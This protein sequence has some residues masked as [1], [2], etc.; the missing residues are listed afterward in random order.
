MTETVTNAGPAPSDGGTQPSVQPDR[1]NVDGQI[2]PAD[3]S[4][5]VN[6]TPSQ[7]TSAA[8]P[9]PNAPNA[10]SQKTVPPPPP[11]PAV[12]KASMGANIV[13]NIADVLSPP[14]FKTEIQPDGSSKQARVPRDRKDVGMAIAL[15]ALTGAFNGLGQQGPNHLGRAAAAGFQATSAQRQQQQQQMD[16]QSQADFAR[17]QGVLDFNM[18]LRSAAVSAGMQD[19]E[20]NDSV[21]NAMAPIADEALNSPNAGDIVKGGTKEAPL[22]ED[23]ADDIKKHSPFNLIRV[24]VAT[25]PRVDK[26]G[27]QVWIGTDNKVVPEGTPGAHRGWDHG[28][29][30]LDKNAKVSL[31][32]ENG[33]KDWVKEAVGKYSGIIP[34]L[35]KSLVAG[36]GAKGEISAYTAGKIQLR[37][38]QLDSTQKTLDSFVNTIN[39]GLNPENQVKPIDLVD[40]LKSGKISLKD[41]DNLQNAAGNS[42]QGNSTVLNTQLDAIRAKDPKSAARLMNLFGGENLETYKQSILAKGAAMK[43]E[44]EKRQKGGEF[45]NAD[46]ALAVANDPTRP[47]ALRTQANNYLNSLSDFEAKKAANVEE[48]KQQIQQRQADETRSYLTTPPNWADGDAEKGQGLSMSQTRQ[49]LESKGVKVPEN[50]ATLY[51]VANNQDDIGKALTTRLSKGTGQMDHDTA[52]SFI[53][54]FLDPA[55]QAS[56]YGAAKKLNEELA[57]TKIGTA[58]GTLLSAGVASQHL[59][60]MAPLFEALNNNDLPAFN[61]ILNAASKQTGK[62]AQVVAKLYTQMVATE[63]EKVVSGSAPHEAQLG[64]LQKQINTDLSPEAAS[65]VI[66]GLMDLMHARL[67]EINSRNQQY[68]KRPVKGVSQNTTDF[69]RKAGFSTPWDQKSQAQQQQQQTQQKQQKL[70]AITLP[71]GGHPV[72]IKYSADGKTTIVSDGKQWINLATGQPYV[73]PKPQ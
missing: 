53:T 8:G 64:E 40:S 68:F 72:D 60:S 42:S 14:S 5:P 9:N 25:V 45:E 48:A 17:K 59:Q 51:S 27:N 38:T 54:T 39:E 55:F 36:N 19:K 2:T 16:A 4:A 3:Q 50:F 57:S 7:D 35:D 66:K 33:A 11:H 58:G 1:S 41:L 21:V 6:Q 49:Y 43:A 62:S 37:V 71:S 22:S 31:S 29:I 15:A 44:M 67:S 10:V 23:E 18:R 65:G 73:A 24:P 13:K 61:R 69:F 63:V 12:Q 56:D 32:D 46:Q 47:E 28:Y 34:G 70:Q 20:D 30:L 52:L 26:D